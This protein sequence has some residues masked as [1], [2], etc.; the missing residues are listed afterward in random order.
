MI[1]RYIANSRAAKRV[2][3]VLAAEIWKYKDVNL[4]FD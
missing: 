2:E 1:I 3:K 4:P